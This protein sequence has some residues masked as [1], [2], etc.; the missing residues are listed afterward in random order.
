ML[1]E[2]RVERF[3]KKRPD[4][5]DN[6]I[7]EFDCAN[8]SLWYLRSK[9]D[10]DELLDT[11]NLEPYH[12]INDSLTTPLGDHEMKTV[13]LELCFLY[14]LNPEKVKKYYKFLVK[15]QKDIVKIIDKHF[16]LLRDPLLNKKKEHLEKS[17]Q[18]E[19]EKGNI[20]GLK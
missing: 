13:F 17:L 15:R 19:K 7:Q 14:R 2:I 10:L 12:E 8:L 3:R 4:Y 9:K 11:F 16:K 18:I 1:K 5:S 6:I 20:V